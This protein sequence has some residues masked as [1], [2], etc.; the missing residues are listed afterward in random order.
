M[1]RAITEVCL[2]WIPLGAGGRVVRWNGRLYEAVVA[3]S[4]SLVAWLLARTGHDM[5]AI[6]PPHALQHG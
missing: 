2:Y 6:S 4:N 3:H 1:D 5:T